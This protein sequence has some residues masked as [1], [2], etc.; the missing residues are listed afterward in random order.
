MNRVEHWR[1]V[2]VSAVEQSGGFCVPDFSEPLALDQV[3][4]APAQ[5]DCARLL[6]DP[7]GGAGLPDSLPGNRLQIVT[8][9]EG[10][11]RRTGAETRRA[12]RYSIIALGPRILR[13]ETAPLAVLAI[14]AASL[15]RHG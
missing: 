15:R 14:P 3:L 6:F 4:Q 2:A 13:T 10:G 5:A 11:L 1:R 7:S 8:G 9:P 12:L